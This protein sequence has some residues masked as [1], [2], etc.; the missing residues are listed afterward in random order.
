[1][2][3]D[4]FTWLEEEIRIKKLQML[5]HILCYKIVNAKISRE[6]AL[7]EIEK[8]REQAEKL[9]PEDMDKFDLIYKSRFHRLIEQFLDKT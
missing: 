4:Y 9:F 8:T 6:Q 1:M 5:S 3:V 7:L 2:F